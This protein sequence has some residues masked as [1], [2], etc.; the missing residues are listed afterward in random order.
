MHRL[1]LYTRRVAMFLAEC[2]GMSV[3]KAAA[4][5]L[6]D[7]RTIHIIEDCVGKG[8]PWDQC[9]RLIVQEKRDERIH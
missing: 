8:L 1:I 7:L 9:A 6:Y 3:E 4:S 2:E 5:V